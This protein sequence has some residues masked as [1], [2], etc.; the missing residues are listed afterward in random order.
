[1]PSRSFARP[2]VPAEIGFPRLPLREMVASQEFRTFAAMVRVVG[3]QGVG[4]RTD[5]RDELIQESG[6]DMVALLDRV[7]S[8][9]P[10]NSE[11]RVNE[12]RLRG[13]DVVEGRFCS[14]TLWLELRPTP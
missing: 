10:K 11:A 3:M 9:R 8:R 6:C 2:S 14:Q 4:Q 7:R 13:R 5:W 12:G 1:M